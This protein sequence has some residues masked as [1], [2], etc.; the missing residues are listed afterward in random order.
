MLRDPV[1]ASLAASRTLCSEGNKLMEEKQPEKAEARLAEA[2]KVC[3][4]DCDARRYYAEA[5]CAA[6]RPAGGRGAVGRGVPA[7]SRL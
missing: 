2:V 7:Q 5:L 4:T 3:P 1:P 6:Q